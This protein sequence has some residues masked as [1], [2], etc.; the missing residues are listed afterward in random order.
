MLKNIKLPALPGVYFFK[1]RN[2]TIIYVGKAKSLAKRVSSYFHAQERDWKIAAL[3]QE[4]ATIEHVVT[5]SETEALLLEAQL[6]RDNKPKYN[7]L[8]KHGNPFIYL[9]VTQEELAE[10]KIGTGKKRE[11]PL[12]W[13]FFAKTGCT[14][15]LYLPI[16]CF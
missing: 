14:C 6:I 10:I 3:L 11:G 15:G 5:Q 13:A 16:T 7:V 8:L 4:Y 9:L 12:F 2:N 1:D